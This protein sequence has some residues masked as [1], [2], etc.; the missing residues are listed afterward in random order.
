MQHTATYYNALSLP[1]THCNNYTDTKPADAR[2]KCVCVCLCFWAFLQVN[3]NRYTYMCVCAY[4][5]VHTTCIYIY[6]YIHTHSLSHTHIF[7]IAEAPPTLNILR[8][9]NQC[10]HKH[11]AIQCAQCIALLHSV[12]HCMHKHTG[13][14]ISIQEMCTVYCSVLVRMH[15]RHVICAATCR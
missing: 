3:I 12:L 4:V 8:H 13:T 7:Y 2:P 14:S 1:A 6:T 15:C 5:Y 11:T 9:Q 10:M